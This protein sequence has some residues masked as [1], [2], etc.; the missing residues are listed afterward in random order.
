MGVKRSQPDQPV[1]ASSG[2][3]PGPATLALPPQPCRTGLIPHK[4]PLT[5]SLSKCEPHERYPA[6]RT[7]PPEANS[8]C[9]LA[10]TEIQTSAIRASAKPPVTIPKRALPT[11]RGRTAASI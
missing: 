1:N 2:P 8:S 10:H 9:P 7:P 3:A 6:H 4:H 5:L 11:L